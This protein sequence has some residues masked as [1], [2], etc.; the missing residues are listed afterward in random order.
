MQQGSLLKS[1]QVDIIFKS[2]EVYQGER[3]LISHTVGIVHA[4]YLMVK[5]LFSLE[6]EPTTTDTIM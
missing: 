6:A 5:P 3:P 1:S 4:G 2:K